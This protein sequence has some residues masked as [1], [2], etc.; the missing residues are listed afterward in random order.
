MPSSACKADGECDRRSGAGGVVAVLFRRAGQRVVDRGV[1]R[2]GVVGRNR[3][4][5]SFPTRRSSDLDRGRA[6]RHRG[7]DGIV[8]GDGAGGGALGGGNGDVSG[9]AAAVG[10]R[11]ENGSA[12]V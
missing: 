6:H 5:H 7:G 4:V 9:A 1:L 3:I 2:R 12:H 11:Q 8:V 10:Q